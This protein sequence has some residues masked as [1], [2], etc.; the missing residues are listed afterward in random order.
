MKKIRNL[1]F[2]MMV[3]ILTGCS[4]KDQ[5]TNFIPTQAP[6]EGSTQEAT[7]IVTEDGSEATPTPKEIH[8]GQTV[9]KYVKLSEYDDILN[10]RSTPS[11]ELAPVGFLVHT[12]EVQVVEIVDGWA[13]ILYNDTI[14]YVNADYLVDEKPAY[15][16]PPPPSPTPKDTPTPTPDPNKDPADI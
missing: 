8:V 6:G 15:L 1:F 13:S 4:K 2:I 9:T 10:V 7:P 12:E 16:T 5:M 3:L 11:T 14:C